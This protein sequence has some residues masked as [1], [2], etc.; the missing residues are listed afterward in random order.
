M[1][2]L[3][4][5]A[6]SGC[7]NWLNLKFVRGDLFALYVTYTTA[8]GT[9]IDITNATIYMTC[10]PA[11]NMPDSSAIFAI[12]TT[13]G[14]I[15]KTVPSAGQFVVSVPS[16]AT[17]N[18][19]EQLFPAPYNIVVEVGPPYTSSLGLSGF[20]GL[21]GQGLYR[22]TVFSGEICLIPNVLEA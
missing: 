7:S 5:T 11:L 1:S 16:S 13:S 2:Q 18:A 3:C 8:D 4:C 15:V 12:S 17:L 20:S 6:R 19:Q 14:D 21:S 10:K 22:V 9:P